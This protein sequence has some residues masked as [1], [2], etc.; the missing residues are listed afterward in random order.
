MDF[1]QL[2]RCFIIWNRRWRVLLL[3][4]LLYLLS[5]GVSIVALALTISNITPDGAIASWTMGVASFW[6]L[7]V[8]LNI[9]LT[10]LIAG[11]IFH[12]KTVISKA[13]GPVHAKVY[14]SVAALVIESAALYTIPTLFY[15]TTLTV[16]TFGAQINRTGVAGLQ[17]IIGLLEVIA[18]ILIVY[19][20]ARG[21]AFSN[22]TLTMTC[23][24][25]LTD[26]SQNPRSHGDLEHAIELEHEIDPF[27]ITQVAG[28]GGESNEQTGTIA[29]SIINNGG[30]EK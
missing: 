19:R 2:Y 25:V 16:S 12:L 4:G 1:Y 14:T 22:R 15:A 17:P 20:I 18:P 28:K 10:S 24:V 29:Q 7:S 26:A 8:V 11:R 5:F 13:V 3:P 23:K 9:I 30:G 27:P 21:Q 6:P